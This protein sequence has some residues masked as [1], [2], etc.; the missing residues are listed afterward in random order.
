[1]ARHAA[2]RPAAS[3]L[4]AGAAWVFT[5]RGGVWTQEGDK[6]VANGAVGSARQGMSVALS[7]DG[8][9]ALVGGL[10][11]DGGV[12]AASEF[13]RSGGQWTQNKKLVG[14]GAIAASSV[15]LSGDGSIAMI[16]ASNDSGGV[17]ATWVFARSSP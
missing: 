4:T 2:C 9:T 5:R 6:L 16:G 17:G 15:A 1:M 7:A 3:S 14:T 8:N 11:D 13:T 10:V 12:G